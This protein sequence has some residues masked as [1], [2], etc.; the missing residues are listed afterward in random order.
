MKLR[1][2]LTQV[3]ARCVQI[4]FREIFSLFPETVRLKKRKTFKAYGGVNNLFN[5]GYSM[6]KWKYTYSIKSGVQTVLGLCT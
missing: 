6:L 3:E 5:L 2:K 1:Q 4:Y